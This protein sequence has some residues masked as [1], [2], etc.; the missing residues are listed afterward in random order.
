MFKPSSVKRLLYLTLVL[1]AFVNQSNAQ[2]STKKL[3]REYKKAY[4]PY[5]EK[6]QEIPDYLTLTAAINMGEIEFPA[7][8]YT[9][10]EF[11]RYDMKVMGA[12]FYAVSLD[13]IS[14]SYNPLS[15][16]YEFDNDA[17]NSFG[18]IASNLNE[19]ESLESFLED[20]WIP[21]KVENVKLDSIQSYKLSL[22]KPEYE[23]VELF[24]DIDTYYLMGVKSKEKHFYYLDYKVVNEQLI[25][26]VYIDKNQENGGLVMRINE[27][28]FQSIVADSLFEFTDEVKKAY[29][30]SINPQKKSI[31]QVQQL[32]NEGIALVKEGNVDEG[33]AKYNKA[34]ELNTT[35]IVVF[36]ARGLAYIEKG[37]YYSAIADF[38]RAIEL[39]DKPDANYHN[40]LGLAKYYLG[41]NDGAK[42]DYDLSLKLDSANPTIHSNMGLLYIRTKD[43]VKAELS[44]DKAIELDTTNAIR[45]YYR[46]FVKA[47]Q[48][49]YDE[50]DIDY[51]KANEMGVNG[52]AF[53]NYWGVAKY[54]LDEYE[55]ALNLF[56]EA[57]LQDS[58]DVQYIKNVA[59]VYK[60][61]ENGYP[62]VIDIYSNLI[63]KDSTNSEYYAER[64]IAH[65]QLALYK[66]ARRDID[67][68]IALYSENALYYDYRA[69]IKEFSGDYT[70]AI[71][72]FTMSLN[73]EQDPNIYYRRGLAKINISNKFDACKDF[74]KSSELGDENGKEALTEHCNL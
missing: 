51:S 20:D 4:K 73:L 2:I 54:Q 19:N 26:H 17:G 53:S 45:V 69:Y 41:D 60:Y 70:G 15:K 30:E 35:D 46:G 68:A 42:S 9:K 66:A 58:T 63:E 23:P 50:A 28:D 32:Y 29:Q 43:F 62:K 18:N 47:Q 65:Y 59:G 37:D 13:T 52:A 49:K 57:H 36:N 14:W 7:I 11:S 31:S 61:L 39:S 10:G 3:I 55:E 64:A 71:E 40:N 12:N 21:T 25:P 56:Q 33:I 38:K 34:L 48:G 74:K 24:F 72:D 5:L 27:F 22:T 8:F 6:N 67:Q 16:E 44:Y 1:I